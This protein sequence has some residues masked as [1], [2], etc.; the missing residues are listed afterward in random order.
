MKKLLIIWRDVNKTDIPIIDEQHRGIVSVINSLHDSL[1]TKREIQILEPA[2][3]M[4]VAY[5]KIHFMTEY[6]LLEESNYPD[7]V[8]HNKLHEKLIKDMTKHFYE[9]RNEKDSSIMLDFLKEWWLNHIN[10]EDMRYKVHLKKY[11][12]IEG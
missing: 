8:A 2:T 6:E 11:L 5:S 10:K 4:L 12:G 9:S 1:G 7:L 3:E